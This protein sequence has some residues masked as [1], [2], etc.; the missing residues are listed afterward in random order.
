VKTV[1]AWCG[2]ILRPG[3]PAPVSHGICRGCRD[4][5]LLGRVR[6]AP[7]NQPSPLPAAFRAH[8]EDGT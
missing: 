6:E 3:P 1:C 7:L 2:V 8:D 5:L 4:R